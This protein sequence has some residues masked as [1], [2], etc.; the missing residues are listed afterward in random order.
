[1][2][3]NMKSTVKKEQKQNTATGPTVS[4]YHTKGSSGQILRAI[5]KCFNNTDYFL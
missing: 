1:M 3:K 2:K 4:L 5:L